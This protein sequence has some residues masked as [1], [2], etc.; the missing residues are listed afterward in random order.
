[1]ILLRKQFDSSGFL[2]GS[3]LAVNALPDGYDIG[4]FVFSNDLIS[5]L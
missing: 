3:L 4:V 5:A 1:M 2:L